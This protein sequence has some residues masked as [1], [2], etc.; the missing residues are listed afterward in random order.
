[1]LHGR[2]DER[3]RLATL[4]DDA[5][6]G[7]AGSLLLHGEPGVGKSALLEDLV[8]TAGDD[9]RVLRAQGVESE[10]PL[11]FAA[12]HRLLRPVLGIL[13]RVPAPQARALRA[14]FG[15]VDDV[16]VEPF[17]AA[18][19]TLSVLTEAA[20]DATVLCVLD[21]AQWLDQATTDAVLVAARRL[22]ADRV[23][24]VFAARDGEGHAFAPDGVPSVAL[25]PLTSG[26]ARTLLAEA[27]G[28][29]VP[30]EV[31][32]RL[33]AQAAGNPLAL[34][35][36]PST[37]SAEQLA[38]SEPLPTQLHLTAG[39]E[40]VFLDRCRR[41]PPDV[42]TLLLVAAADDSGHV[43]TVRAAATQL[44]AAPDSLD[45]AERSGL[46]VVDGGIVRVRH[47]LVRSAVYQAATS[48]ER[49]EAHRALADAL[50]PQADPDRYAWHRA[51]AVDSPDQDV[52]TGMTA[53]GQRAERRGG[54]AAASAAYQRAAELTADEQARAPLLY[55]AARTAWSAG[56]TGNARALSTA[57]RELA[58][59]R[60]LRAD[61]DRLRGRIEV[62]VGSAADAHHTFAAAARAV[63]AD[64]P[65]RALELAV[66]A[67]LLSTYGADSGTTLDTATLD[68]ATLATDAI[69]SHAT[70]GAAPRT[71]CLGHLLL[72]LTRAAAYDWAP[73]LTS[74]RDALKVGADM[75]DLDL[76]SH[77]GNTAL[78]LGDDEAHHRCF[79]AM[80]AGARDAGA[81]ML[82]LYALPR[83]GFSQVITGRWSALRGSAE[84]ALSLSASTGQP[85]LAAA[86]LG[87]LT[88][89]AALQ[90]APTADYDQ[91]RSDLD[92]AARQPLGV[93]ADPVHDLTRWAQGTRAAHDG[94]TR[95]ALHDFASIRISAINRLTVVDRIDAA[96]RAGDHEQAA[97][98]VKELTPFAEG[99]GWPWALAALNHG[100]ALLAEPRDVPALFETALTH[101]A[102]AAAQGGGRPYDRART[103]LAYGELLR[104]TQHRVDARTHLRAALETFEDLRAEPLAARASQELRASGET[105]R[106]RDPSTQLTLTP[107]ERQVAGL[108]RQ[109]LSNKDIA[110][111]CWVSPRTVAF[112]LRNIFTKAGVTS[113]GELAQLDLD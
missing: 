49:R 92:T 93:L 31:A 48:R 3:A 104:R 5:R 47:P 78:H 57:A 70:S 81:G 34:V 30:D 22:G 35:E 36:L 8:A 71:R 60:T 37:L 44:G 107:M 13:D 23:A 17:L 2:G 45:A 112:H 1:V 29:T 64:D 103:H 109:G 87:W 14:A 19:A 95:A 59:E 113:R 90:G 24:V 83:L 91:Q 105:A 66:A 69:T 82:V 4:L 99:T 55:A 74:L 76:L 79:T 96:V 28:A 15:E 38:G 6:G 50:G 20:E 106:K 88:V 111:Q 10:A 63:L 89:L 33:M 53:A 67:A 101:H 54:Y 85:A 61:I 43:A 102:D 73:A 11:P 100:R 62:N 39:I 110:A 21:D 16:A 65:T 41:L 80:A 7:R 77:L 40:R 68:T 51:A 58:D 86:P 94:D 25:T 18:L 9:V 72:A 42:Q 27:A 32:D 98:W 108:V 84:E 75:G 12:L 56:Q 26:A 52:V 97:A 46:L